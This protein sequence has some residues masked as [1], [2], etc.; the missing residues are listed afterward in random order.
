MQ[1]FLSAVTFDLAGFLALDLNGDSDLGEVSRRMSRVATLDL[2]AAFNDF[3]STAADMTFV[4]RWRPVDRAQVVAVE[5]LV[6]LYSR[7]RLACHKGVFLTAPQG[8]K[9]EADKATLT[10]L[11]V[12]QLV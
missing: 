12:E 3:G 4:L 8:V 11:A 5:R 10:L 1:V 7:L 6:A 9:V 2:G